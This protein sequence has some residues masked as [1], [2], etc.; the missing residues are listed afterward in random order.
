MGY[1]CITRTKKEADLLLQGRLLFMFEAKENLLEMSHNPQDSL[2]PH[3]E[4][5][6]FHGNRSYLR[7]F[8]HISCEPLISPE[9][10]P[11]SKK[12]AHIPGESLIFQKIRSYLRKTAHIPKNPLISLENRPYLRKTA[13]IPW[14]SPITL[15]IRSYF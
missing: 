13:H 8:A 12:S 11:Y 9:N 7:E 1:S 4:A 3:G 2:I 15:S 14:N 5:P 10:H 6:I